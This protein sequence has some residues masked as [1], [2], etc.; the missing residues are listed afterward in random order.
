MAQLE[1]G[2]RKSNELNRKFISPE[3][4]ETIQGGV[5][6]DDGDG[7][8]F[9][10]VRQDGTVIAPTP[11]MEKALEMARTFNISTEVLTKEEYKKRFG[12]ELVW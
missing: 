3:E 8:K 11:G 9:W 1:G 12:R 6:V 2:K 5:I 7:E 10:L 4:T